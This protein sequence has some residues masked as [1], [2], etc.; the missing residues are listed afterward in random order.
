MKIF[1]DARNPRFNGS[2]TYIASLV[3]KLVEL[4][5]DHEY[6]VLYDKVHGPLGLKGVDERVAPSLN[7]LAWIAWS[8]TVL[9][10]LLKRERVDI[11]HSLKQMNSFNG[12]SRKIYTVHG[13]THFV[14]PQFHPWH[15][16]IYWKKLTISAAQRGN[17]I[18]AVSESDKRSLVYWAGIPEEKITTINL[19]PSSKFKVIDEPEVKERIRKRLGLDFPFILFVGRVDPFKNIIGMLK[20]FALAIKMNDMGHRLVIV[21]DRKGYQSSR[22]FELIETLG[23][24]KRVVFTGHIFEDLE[25]VYNLA[26]IFLFPSLYEAFS[27]ALVEAMACGLPVVSTRGAGCVDVVGDAGILVDPLNIEEMAEAIVKVLSSEN[28]RCSLSKASLARAS[29]FSWE[30]CARETFT[31]YERLLA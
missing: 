22:V 1:L 18:I 3:P 28:L 12:P 21:G 19:A 6:I 20:A 29:I 17:Q 9:P 5:P 15:N 8:H 25:V 26:D 24:S 7:P 16:V 27:L 2:W 23:I 30:R 4:Y 13:A 31:L 11:Y 14:Y 10:Q